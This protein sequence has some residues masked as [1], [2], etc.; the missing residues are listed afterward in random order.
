MNNYEKY[1]I[2]KET[3][4]ENQNNDKNCTITKNTIYDITGK[5]QTLQM[6]STYP[7]STLHDITEGS[8]ISISSTHAFLFILPY[9]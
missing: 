6:I 5:Y 2:H 3:N 9:R 4:K 8:S 7:H 1:H